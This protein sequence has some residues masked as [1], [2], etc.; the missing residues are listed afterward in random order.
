MYQINPQINEEKMVA[1]HN[2]FIEF[3][4][5]SLPIIYHQICCV[6]VAIEYQEVYSI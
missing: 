6:W 1:R 5:A 4:Y 3:V 2:L